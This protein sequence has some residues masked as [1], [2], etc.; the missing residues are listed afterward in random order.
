MNRLIVACKRILHRKLYWGML[1]ILLVLTA[2]YSLLPAK[3][4]STEIRVAVY[5]EDQSSYAGQFRQELD[6]STSLYQFYYVQDSD[7][8]IR[9]VQSGDAECGYVIP[10]HFFDGYITGTGDPK[11]LQYETNAGTLSPAICETVF[12]SIFKAASPQIL[13]DTVGDASLS[14]ELKS[15]MQEYMGSDTIFRMSSVTSGAYDYKE[16]TYRIQLPVYECTCVL[17]LFASLFG[18][19]LFLQDNERGIYLALSGR[20][21]SGILYSTLCAAILPIYLVGMLCNGITYGTA[22]LLQ[23]TLVSVTAYL[24]S[25]VLSFFIKKS[26]TLAKLIPVLLL[27]AIAYFFVNY[28]L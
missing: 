18:L 26:R 14:D 24:L 22:T 27:V 13:V 2:I 7:A 6:A 4:Q 16:N 9:D 3:S 15:R 28:I 20:R 1:G 12:L 5:L 17:M 10:E 11:L 19:M 23:I 21:R 25:L 8:V